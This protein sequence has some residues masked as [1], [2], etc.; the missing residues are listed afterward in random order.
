MKL[1]HYQRKK[2]RSVILPNNAVLGIKKDILSKRIISDIQQF[3]NDNHLHVNKI[4]KHGQGD[5]IKF[6]EIHFDN[7]ESYDIDVI[8]EKL[9]QYGY[10]PKS[11]HGN[12]PDSFYLL[13]LVNKKI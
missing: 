1:S 6:Y 7:L 11:L 3:F 2:S 4:L 9:D 10:T 12:L 8:T 5:S 13:V